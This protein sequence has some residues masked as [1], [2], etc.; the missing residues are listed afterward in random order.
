MNAH[1]VG[2]ASLDD[3]KREVMRLLEQ[4]DLTRR[5]AGTWHHN[6][7]LI[8]RPY[9]RRNIHLAFTLLEEADVVIA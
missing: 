1:V 8:V 3:R 2:P 7:R 4:R 5:H 9:A 6:E